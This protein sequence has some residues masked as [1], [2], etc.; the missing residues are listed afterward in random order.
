M[1]S[2]NSRLNY[3]KVASEVHILG[4][5]MALLVEEGSEMHN[6]I[7]QTKLMNCTMAVTLQAESPSM[8]Q[9][10]STTFLSEKSSGEER[11]LL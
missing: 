11:G 7:N 5:F 8:F 2:F 1:T 10:T 9:S 6:N 4:P 3:E